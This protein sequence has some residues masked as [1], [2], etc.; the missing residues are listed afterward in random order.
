MTSCR[1]PPPIQTEDSV[2]LERFMGDWWVHANVPTFI[3]KGVWNAL[4]QYELNED[5]TVATTFSFNKGAADGPRKTYYPKGFVRDTESNAVWDMQFIWPIKA[6]YR[7][8]Y[9]DEDYTET[10]IGRRKRDY[11]W[12]MFRD[13]EVAEERLQALIDFAVEQGYEREAILRVPLVVGFDPD[14]EDGSE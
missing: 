12:I 3:E 8:L 7:I 2:D 4:E 13:Q 14:A 1:T 5:G 9:V 10:V 11:L 6:E